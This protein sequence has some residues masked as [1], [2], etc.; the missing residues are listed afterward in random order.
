MSA[1]N[2]EI[3]LRPVAVANSSIDVISDGR[4]RKIEFENLYLLCELP[5]PS[6]VHGLLVWSGAVVALRSA[7]TLSND[8]F[9][10]Y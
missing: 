6:R 4:S 3:R 5:L 9:K 10:P 7:I 2:D 8:A 1:S